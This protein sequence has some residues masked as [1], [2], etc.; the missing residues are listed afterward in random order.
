MIF[1]K[2]SFEHVFKNLPLMSPQQ[3]ILSDLDKSYMKRWTTQYTFLLIKSNIP[4]ET[5]EID[6]FRFSHYKSLENISCHSNQSS[7]P[8][9]TKT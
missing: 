2:K 4:N 8:I 3:P 6:N 9:G 7:Y 5:S 1:E